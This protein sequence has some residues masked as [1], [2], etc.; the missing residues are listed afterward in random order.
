MAMVS[1]AVADR[2]ASTGM[3][4]AGKGSNRTRSVLRELRSV[5]GLTAAP[6]GGPVIAFQ[7][8]ELLPFSFI[9]LSGFGA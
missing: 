6:A 3:R 5:A 1:L 4:P 7:T 9:A 2:N 8:T